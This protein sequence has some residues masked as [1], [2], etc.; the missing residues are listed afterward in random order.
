[1][2]RILDGHK[3]E[4]VKEKLTRSQKLDLQTTLNIC[5]ASE[6]NDENKKVVMNR[7]EVEVSKVSHQYAKRR[8]DG[9]YKR[10]KFCCQMH[11]MKKNSCPA[12]GKMCNMCKKPNHFAS[13][14]ACESIRLMVNMEENMRLKPI[15]LDHKRKITAF[16]RR[17]YMLLMMSL[18][19][20]L[21]KGL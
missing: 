10:C 15:K 4:E 11:P 7:T 5:Q 14:D 13:S 8:S 20:S 17:K 3:I 19:M 9:H 18:V 12:W 2:D 21:L 1:M 6:L 16:Q